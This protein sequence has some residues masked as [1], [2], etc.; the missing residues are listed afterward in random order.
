MASELSGKN[1][2]S[3]HFKPQAFAAAAANE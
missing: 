2:Q 1:P 3:M